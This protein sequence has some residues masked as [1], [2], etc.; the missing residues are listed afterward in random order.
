MQ[1]YVDGTLISSASSTLLSVYNSPFSASARID[2]QESLSIGGYD[3]LTQN[4]SGY[5]DEIRIYNK[6]LNNTEVGYL[7]DRT[8]GGTMLQTNIVGNLFSKQGLAII[9][10]PDYRYNDIL[11][12]PYTASYKST[13]T[14]N[15]LSVLAKLDAGDFNMSLNNSLTMDND[16]TYQSFVTS[17]AF[18][19]YITT[20]G[21][22]DNAGQ[23]LAIGKVAQPIKKRDD[24]DMNF[25]I[26][27]DLDKNIQ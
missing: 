23:L 6:A 18:S 24:V 4:F 13:K 14:I 22:Y 19:P 20:I 10:S 5:L 26:R 21:L 1:M 11:T 16:I 8:E 27:I 15:E 3:A 2:N 12:M 9:S 25:L 7:S 17:S